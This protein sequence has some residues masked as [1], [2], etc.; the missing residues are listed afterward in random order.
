VL[1]LLALMALVVVATVRGVVEQ[2]DQIG[3]SVDAA[4]D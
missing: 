4:L 3:A 2:T 1:G